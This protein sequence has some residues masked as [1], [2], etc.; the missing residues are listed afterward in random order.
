MPADSHSTLS[1]RRLL[2]AGGTAAV[3]AVA[4]CSA[5]VNFIGDQFLEDVNIFNE[6]D[7]ELSGTITV[8]GPSDE[9]R[10]EESFEVATTDSNDEGNIGTFADVWTEA[11]SYEVTL[12]LDEDVEGRSMA[13]ETVSVTDT[14]DEMLGIRVGSDEVDEPFEFEIADDLTDLQDDD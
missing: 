4:G 10:L 6:T 5:I 13:S 14:G 9:T 1:R 12:E 7:R 2:A 11:G 3:T 8:V